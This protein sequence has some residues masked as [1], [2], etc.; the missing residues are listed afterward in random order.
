MG[1]VED[2]KPITPV[3]LSRLLKPFPVTSR[4]VRIEGHGTPRGYHLEDLADAFDRYIPSLTQ[5]KPLLKCN[6]ATTRSQRGDDPL[7]QGATDSACCT[8]E[9]GL[10]P[11]PRAECCTVALQK[12]EIQAE[13]TLFEESEALDAFDVGVP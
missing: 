5:E 10:N 9:Y 3:Q 2:G 11:A 1:N 12:P 4:A 13:K 8:S 7:F 6:T